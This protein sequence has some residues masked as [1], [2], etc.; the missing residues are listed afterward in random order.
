M[1]EPR[2]VTM[3]RSGRASATKNSRHTPARSSGGIGGALGAL[4]GFSADW[5]TM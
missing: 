3:I 4:A 5:T 1:I 2:T